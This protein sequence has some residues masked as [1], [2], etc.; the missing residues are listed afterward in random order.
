MLGH[1]VFVW[2]M[3]VVF[4]VCMAY[5]IYGGW[6]LVCLALERRNLFWLEIRGWG[7]GKCI[8]KCMARG[9]SMLTSGAYVSYGGWGVLV[10]HALSCLNVYFLYRI[11]KKALSRKLEVMLKKGAVDTVTSLLIFPIQLHLFVF[12]PHLPTCI[13]QL[14]SCILD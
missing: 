1:S 13:Q 5:V 11:V 7:V 3:C 10:E 4:R 2:N 14:R 6:W 12:F 9:G 8:C